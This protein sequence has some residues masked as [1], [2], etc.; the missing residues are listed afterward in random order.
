MIQNIHAHVFTDVSKDNFLKQAPGNSE[1]I[2]NVKF[3]FGTKIDESCDVLIVFNR[4]SFTLKT[5][6]FGHVD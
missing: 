4:S 3:T 1:K 6:V 5:N 2:K